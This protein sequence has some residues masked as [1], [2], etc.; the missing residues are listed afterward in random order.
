LNTRTRTHACKYKIKNCTTALPK[1]TFILLFT[2]LR[3]H[4]S[5]QDTDCDGRTD[6]GCEFYIIHMVLHKILH[7]RVSSVGTTTDYWFDG[8]RI[9]VCRVRRFSSPQHPERL[10]DP[11]F[12]LI[13]KGVR[14]PRIEAHYSLLLS[15]EVRNVRS[16]ASTSRYVFM[17]PSLIKQAQRQIYL[18]CLYSCASANMERAT[19]TDMR[20]RSTE[21]IRLPLITALCLINTLELNSSLEAASRSATQEF[22]SIILKLKVNFRVH[23]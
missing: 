3:H 19:H 2:L 13:G 21:H 11:A 18:Y 9:E 5:F 23:K 4:Y 6:E 1:I 17:V 10:C 22:R 7:S 15:D 14:Q 16:Y 20:N 8:E 12:Y